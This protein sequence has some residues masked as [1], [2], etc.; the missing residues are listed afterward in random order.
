MHERLDARTCWIGDIIKR[1]IDAQSVP[2][3]TFLRSIF[4]L[5]INGYNDDSTTANCYVSA[6]SY[7]S[8]R[9]FVRDDWLELL[10]MNGPFRRFRMLA[11]V[12]DERLLF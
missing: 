6:D 11:T 10:N 2:I 9:V 8:L 12:C 5:G 3:V 7:A 1:V 4:P